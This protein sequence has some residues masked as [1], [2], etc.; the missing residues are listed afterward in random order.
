MKIVGIIPT[1][2][3][4]SRFPGKP[5]IDIGGKTMIQRVYEQ[6]LK[7]NL[8][9]IIIATDDERIHNAAKSFNANVVMTQVSHQNGTE[10]C[11]EVMQILGNDFDACIN[12]QGDEPF[13]NPEQINKVAALLQQVH[14]IVT[15]KKKITIQ[16][17]LHNNNVVKVV[18][19][20]KD[21]ALYF[22]RSVIPFQRNIEQGILENHFKHIGIYGFS[23]NTLEEIVQLPMSILEK[24]ESLEQLRW[25]EN[26]YTIQVAETIFETIAIDTPE[27]L[28]KIKL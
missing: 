16:E 5:L 25:L 20:K 21:E 9:K 15:L 4:A 11:A 13:I 24:T 10:R 1:R 6:A 22:S 17:E 18:C 3:A 19:N 28:Q 12:I 23:K 27:D 26:G 2:Y 7:A 14:N 8:A